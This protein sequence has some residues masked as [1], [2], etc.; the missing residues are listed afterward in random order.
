MK[1]LTWRIGIA[2]LTFTIGV[3]ATTAWVFQSRPP[4]I[5]PLD[6]MLDPPETAG[7]AANKATLEMVFVLDTTGSMGGL[8][9][10]A[11]QRI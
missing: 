10:G 6:S 3:G 1:A 4:I 9:E 2:L 7:G 8:I 11:K 5:E